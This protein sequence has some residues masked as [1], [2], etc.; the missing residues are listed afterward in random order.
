MRNDNYDED[1]KLANE[2]MKDRSKKF[3]NVHNR[4]P[5][6]QDIIDSK[7]DHEFLDKIDVWLH[8]N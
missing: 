8:C 2:E 7:F 6:P 1:R 4:E 5:N 3:K